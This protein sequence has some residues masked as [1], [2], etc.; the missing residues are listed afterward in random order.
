[1][2]VKKIKLGEKKFKVSCTNGPCQYAP[3]NRWILVGCIIGAVVRHTSLYTDL[4][5]DSGDY[6]LASAYIR[7]TINREH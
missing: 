7:I 3:I 5:D 4:A 2:I 6:Y 1:M